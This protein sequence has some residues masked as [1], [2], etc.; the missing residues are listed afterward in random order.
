MST[1]TRHVY[2][3]IDYDKRDQWWHRAECL[4]AD[5]ELFHRTKN[6]RD[7][8]EAAAKAYCARCPVTTECLTD[9][10]KTDDRESIRGGLT[11]RERDTMRD[12]AYVS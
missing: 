10:I 8:T 7:K 6:D 12:G 2:H 3:R 4:T 1:R 9:A 5:P 11:A